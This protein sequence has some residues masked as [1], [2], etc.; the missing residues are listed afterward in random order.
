[1]A[2]GHKDRGCSHHG[3]HSGVGYYSQEQQQIRYVMVCDECGIEVREVYVEPYAPDP[4][5]GPGTGF[6]QEV[7]GLQA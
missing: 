6:L 3:Y 2:S 1:M 7:Q 5:I 4:V